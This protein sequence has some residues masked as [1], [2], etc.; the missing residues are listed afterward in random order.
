LGPAQ[1]KSLIDACLHV[2][3]AVVV[4]QGDVMMPSPKRPT[5]GMDGPLVADAIGQ[6]AFILFLAVFAV[7]VWWLAIPPRLDLSLDAVL[8]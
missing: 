2:C 8:R 3:S 7:V 5:N 4:C 6:A 1:G